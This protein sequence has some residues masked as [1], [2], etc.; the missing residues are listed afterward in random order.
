MCAAG[1]H[2]RIVRAA[3]RPF[4]TGM[5]MSRITRSGCSA[6]ALSMASCPLEASP[7]ISKSGRDA[8]V[9]QT[10]LLTNS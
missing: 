10:R 1:Q 7:Q 4:T 2:S 8:K 5:V 6:L 3:S 9:E